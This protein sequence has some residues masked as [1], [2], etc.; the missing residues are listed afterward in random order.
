MRSC[1]IFKNKIATKK[2]IINQ[3]EKRKEKK[4]KLKRK[5]KKRDQSIEQKNHFVDIV[6]IMS[7]SQFKKK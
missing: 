4:E 6:L 1:C 2:E 5:E 7:V 3:K